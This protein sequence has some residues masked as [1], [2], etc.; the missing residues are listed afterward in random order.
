M[1]YIVEENFFR[2]RSLSLW[3]LISINNEK[4][5][6]ERIYS[7]FIVMHV[8]HFYFCNNLLFCSSSQSWFS[9]VCFP[10]V[11]KRACRSIARGER[12]QP[13]RLPP[14]VFIA[15]S[16][17]SFYELWR[18]NQA[19][20]SRISPGCRINVARRLNVNRIRAARKEEMKGRGGAA[21]RPFHSSGS[22]HCEIFPR[23]LNLH[24]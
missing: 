14:R 19:D 8:N 9:Q 11:G 22:G 7:S 18:V 3:T 4:F 17:I 15:A 21:S 6:L 12:A 2:K 20:F 16:N 10:L 13:V 24:R 23:L 1:H 5:D